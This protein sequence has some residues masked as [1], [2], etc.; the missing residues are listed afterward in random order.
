M[1]HRVR[2]FVRRNR[3]R[4][5]GYSFRVWQS[6]PYATHSDVNHD[7]LLRRLEAAKSRLIIPSFLTTISFLSE[8]GFL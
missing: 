5:T 4:R 8:Y 2:K 1:K 3:A 6:I 7:K